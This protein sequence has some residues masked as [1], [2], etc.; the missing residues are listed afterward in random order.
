MNFLQ[1]IYDPKQL[2]A[3]IVMERTDV[4]KRLYHGSNIIESVNLALQEAVANN[5]SWIA[6]IESDMNFEESGRPD[7]NELMSVDPMIGFIALQSPSSSE[8][9]EYDWEY[10]V[11][12]NSKILIVKVSVLADMGALDGSFATVSFANLDLILRANQ[13]GYRSIAASS[14]F[15]QAT[16]P[17]FNRSDWK[18][19][20][21]KH[22]RI[23]SWLRREKENQRRKQPIKPRSEAP[24]RVIHQPVRS[25]EFDL[26]NL[27]L[28]HDGTAEVACKIVKKFKE[29]F[30]AEFEVSLHAP[31]TVLR[32]HELEG[33][34]P[35]QRTPDCSLR[36]GQIQTPEELLLFIQ[37]APLLGL[38]FLDTIALDCMHLDKINFWKLWN[39]TFMSLDFA[40]FISEFS[41]H[42]ALLRFPDSVPEICTAQL[43]S[44][45]TV[46]YRASFTK[47][48]TGSD[49][50]FVVGNRFAHKDVHYIA[51]KISRLGNKKVIAL[52]D[53]T[54]QSGNISY[55]RSGS[56]SSRKMEELYVN[57][58]V[59]IF[60]SHYEGFGFPIMHA[61]ANRR[62][63]ICRDL[64][65]YHEII[66]K[67]AEGI[68]VYPC[69][70]R[71]DL[72]RLAV[73]KT[74]VWLEP[75]QKVSPVTWLDSADTLAKTIRRASDHR[76]DEYVKKHIS[77]SIVSEYPSLR[78][79]KRPYRIMQSARKRMDALIAP[80]ANLLGYL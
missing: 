27:G 12:G 68:N 49:Y 39:D 60:P 54:E 38:V 15:P 17:S 37:R 48:I 44:T 45:S 3:R 72:I 11:L 77:E 14:S 57:A 26:T 46:E 63:V 1:I 70:S 34:N 41:R 5:L 75:T 31:E 29:R 64:P 80:Y 59:V 23:M 65:V 28:H 73:E 66:E 32:F 8:N 71:S 30:G 78:L 55:I 42:Q 25:I 67:T 9:Q 13:F 56:I 6:L 62:P 47:E 69:R 50:F 21:R 33:S 22:P 61:L 19:L 74:P 10:S 2:N 18:L 7:L 76:R 51:E 40:L 43:L 35:S 20:R 58:S 36:F 4:A 53:K 52:A 24:I 79:G 16:K